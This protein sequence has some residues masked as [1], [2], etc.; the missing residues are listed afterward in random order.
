MTGEQVIGAESER[1][2][3][4]RFADLAILGKNG[5]WR[6]GLAIA[7]FFVLGM[8]LSVAL[9]ALC[10]ALGFDVTILGWTNAPRALSLREEALEFALVFASVIAFLPGLWFLLPWLHR[11]PR[12]TFL[13]GHDRFSWT[14]LWLSFGAALLIFL[15]SLFYFLSRAGAPPA[16]HV[17][18]K[19]Y[20][21]FVVLGLLL[22]PLQVFTEEF[23]FRGYLTQ[24]VGRLT[25]SLALR[26]I[27]PA[28]LFVALHLAN[29][30]VTRNA[31]AAIAGYVLVALYLGV[32]ALRGNGLE[33]AIGFHLANNLFVLFVVGSTVS[34]APSVAPLMAEPDVKTLLIVAPILYGCHYILVF[35][36]LGGVGIARAEKAGGDDRG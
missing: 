25:G 2:E 11:R 31:P 32:L 12:L 22:V 16:L 28:A 27:V 35:A 34:A 7:L 36:L 5:W 19:R 3:T 15:A 24:A 21:V 13:T 17:E 14:R 18:V 8:A 33:E 1:A 4:P 20:V 30:E 23:L 26:L 9:V 6:Y 10:D 29:P